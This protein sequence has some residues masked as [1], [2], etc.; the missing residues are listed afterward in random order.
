MKTSFPANSRRFSARVVRSVGI[1]PAFIASHARSARR[2]SSSE[3]VASSGGSIASR[4]AMS[5][6]SDAPSASDG[7]I[8][9]KNAAPSSVGA[10]DLLVRRQPVGA[11]AG[12]QRHHVPDPP[13]AGLRLVQLLDRH[14]AVGGSA[15]AGPRPR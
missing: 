4:S 15:T 3:R 9:A 2:A 5:P 10:A 1:H 12:Q 8:D 6:S 14:V 7:K 11:L 13:Q